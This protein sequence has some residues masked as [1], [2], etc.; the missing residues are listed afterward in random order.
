MT[1]VGEKYGVG[2]QWGGAYPWSDS[3]TLDSG[4]PCRALLSARHKSTAR[5]TRDECLSWALGVLGR[6]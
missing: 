5:P 4:W 3:V 2:P 6:S 1:A